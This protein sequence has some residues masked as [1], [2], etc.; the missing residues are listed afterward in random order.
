MLE[1]VVAIAGLGGCVII[2]RA[3][4][5]YGIVSAMLFFFALREVLGRFQTSVGG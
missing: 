3:W 4:A 5:V 2:T 1:W